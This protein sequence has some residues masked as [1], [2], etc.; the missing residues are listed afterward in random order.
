MLLKYCF[1]I[2]ADPGIK[3]IDGDDALSFAKN[4]GHQDVVTLLGS[5]K[6]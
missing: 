1:Y 4:N 3:D 2:R 6:K 5:L